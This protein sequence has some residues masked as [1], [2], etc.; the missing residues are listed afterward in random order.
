MLIE[1]LNVLILQ[2]NKLVLLDT[3]GNQQNDNL[4]V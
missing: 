4:P 3:I 1:V 2:L